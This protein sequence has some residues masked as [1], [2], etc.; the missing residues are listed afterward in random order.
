MT[1]REYISQKLAAFGVAEAYYVDIVL[2]SGIVLDD[3]YS[4]ENAAQVGEAMISVL[5]ELMVVPRQSNI[6]E[7]GFSMS[8]DFSGLGKWYILLCKRYGKEADADIV[9]QSGIS[10]IRDMTSVW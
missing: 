4:A 7:G 3:L 8:W 6:S 9:A 5:E 1:V 10:V 2:S